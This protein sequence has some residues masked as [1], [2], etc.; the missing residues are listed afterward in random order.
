[1]ADAMEG[2]K[3]CRCMDCACMIPLHW[4]TGGFECKA[5]I[6]G[7]RAV[8]CNDRWGR[9]TKTAYITDPPMDAWHWC[10]LYTP[11]DQAEAEDQSPDDQQMKG[12]ADDLWA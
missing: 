12:L 9:P 8:P 6:G 4:P 10:R 11:K 2:L 3:H 1:M 7:T 5:W